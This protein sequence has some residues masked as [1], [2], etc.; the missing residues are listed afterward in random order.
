MD[1]RL[2]WRPWARIA[3]PAAICDDPCYS[4]IRRLFDT[5]LKPNE[6]KSWQPGAA[7]YQT[8][9]MSC[10]LDILD[11]ESVPSHSP[12]RRV[13][14]KRSVGPTDFRPYQ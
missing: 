6:W 5:R 1:A 12:R 9:W 8:N 13:W 10:R 14:L 11:G 2:F 4:G 7:G 3:V